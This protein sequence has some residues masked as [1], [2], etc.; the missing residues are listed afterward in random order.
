MIP[1]A[2]I[3][4]VDDDRAIIEVYHNMLEIKGHE[5]I[6]EAFDGENAVNAYKE[7]PLKPDIV[8]MDHRMPFK[9][10]I[11]AMKDIHALD[12]AQCVIFVT[13][14]FEAAKDALKKGAQSFIMKPF[15]MDDLFNSIEM[16]LFEKKK[17]NLELR[18]SYMGYITKLN[19]AGGPGNLASICD[20]VEKEIINKFIPEPFLTDI[21]L[22]TMGNWL[23]EFFNT[24]GFGYFIEREQEK[25]II[26]NNKCIWMDELGPNPNFCHMAKCVIS[27]FASK[28][29]RDFNLQTRM[30]IMDCSDQC[31]FELKFS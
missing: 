17:K 11:K 19:E 3:F 23:C 28:T 25:I 30:V 2:K 21:P 4:L 26:K 1:L 13:A 8:L 24:I 16:A 27:K 22:E 10:G 7:L 5:V 29:G 31:L 12:P 6:G 14:D 18:E 20:M 15:R 9:C